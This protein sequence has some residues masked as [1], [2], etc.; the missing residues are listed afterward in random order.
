MKRASGAT[1]PLV[2]NEREAIAMVGL[3]KRRV[4]GVSGALLLL[5]ALVTMLAA[6]AIGQQGNPPS[7]ECASTDPVWNGEYWKR[8]VNDGALG[9]IETNVAGAISL[10]SDGDWTNN[11]NDP[12]FRII[13]KVG[14]GTGTDQ[15]ISGLWE[16]GEG[17]NIDLDLNGLSHVTF[18]FTAAG[19]PT[20]EDTTPTTEDTTPTTEDTTPTTEDTTP[21]TEGTTS[22]TEGADVGGIVVTLPSS[23]QV[24]NTTASTTASTL[25]FTGMSTGSLAVIGGA[26]AAMGT[27]LL[28]ASRRVQEKS[29]ARHW[30]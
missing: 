9:Q 5:M 2:T 19:P 10:D 8:Q 25:P 14:Q 27:L 29:A 28:V 1:G 24:S 6:P 30:A 15:V 11:N 7:V 23:P 26:L 21:T 17:G 3:A 13:L 20:T 12:V 22:T 16:T 18:C 4:M